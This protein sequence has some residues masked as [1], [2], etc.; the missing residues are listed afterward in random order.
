MAKK[1][2]GKGLQ[3]L[4]PTNI[5]TEAAE[6]TP[7][8]AN[9]VIELAITK[10][11][12]NSKQP[13]RVFDDEKLNELAQSIREYGV[14]QPIIVREVEDFYEIIAGERRWRACQKAGLS[15]IPA[16]I[17]TFNDQEL[18]EIALIENIQRENLNPIE[19]AM[20]YRRLIKEFGLTQEQL[21]Q[22]I[23]KSRPFI[24]NLLRLLNLPA[25]IQE[26]VEVGSLT[27]G[28][29]RSLLTVDD[30]K[31][32]LLFAE[33]IV[34]QGLTVRDI[35]KLVNQNN[36]Q[37]AKKL[38]SETQQEPV[39]IQIEEKLRSHLGTK[40][41][42]KPQGDKGKI[43]IDYYSDDDLNRIIDLFFGDGVF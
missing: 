31:K 12:P 26:M 29:A 15:E 14:V 41:K 3:A 35:E 39:F 11:K 36:N 13:R 30:E 27:I 18:T 17:K 5:S 9:G 8:P 33:Q 20:A 2:L 24:A 21:S 4:I 19:E 32:R 16:I 38:K 7:T 43:E 6:P 28:H 34:K 23:G 37:Q 1:G 10:I 40:V 22:K 42:I 25:A